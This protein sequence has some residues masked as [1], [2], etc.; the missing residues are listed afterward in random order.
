M[1]LTFRQNNAVRVSGI[2]FI[3]W[4]VMSVRRCSTRSFRH[5]VTVIVNNNAVGYNTQVGTFRRIYENNN[6]GILCLYSVVPC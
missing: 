3:Y 6:Y 1:N 5:Y 2:H 4:R